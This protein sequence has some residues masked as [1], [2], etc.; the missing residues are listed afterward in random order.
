MKN[1]KKFS[2]VSHWLVGARRVPSPNR[3]ERPKGEGDIDLLVIH[4]ISLPP[5][6]FGGSYIEDF[7]SNKLDIAKD[8]YFDEISHLRVSSHLLIYRSGEV[9]QF[10]PFSERAWHAG[11]SRFGERV[12]CNDFS[13]G[14]ELEGADDI[15]YTEEQYTCLAEVALAIMNAYPKIVL[16]N[17]VGH[18]DIAP[19]RKT[20]PGPAFKW[21]KLRSLLQPTVSV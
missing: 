16:S 7:F 20:D 19:G 13:I 3:D 9:V 12:R 11:E 2:V 18:S 15:P 14:I 21:S 1:A 10:V 8:P 4:G 17:I 6:R 5:N